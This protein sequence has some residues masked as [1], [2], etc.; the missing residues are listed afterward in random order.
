MQWTEL[1]DATGRSSL[2]KSKGTDAEVA[3]GNPRI[4]CRIG[5]ASVTRVWQKGNVNSKVVGSVLWLMGGLSLMACGSSPAAKQG[6]PGGTGGSGGSSSCPSWGCASSS[7]EHI[8]VL[9]QEN[10]T[11]DNHFGRYCTAPTGSNPT[12]TTGPSCCE[13]GPATDPGTGMMPTVLDDKA[14]GSFDPNHTQAC[15][16]DKMDGGKMDHYISS[17]LGGTQGCGSPQNFAYAAPSIIQP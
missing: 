14:M 4:S 12:C 2:I 3:A 17:T 9:I 13:A 8:V 11:F 10:H 6:P 15:E 16:L 7:I 1:R 5:V